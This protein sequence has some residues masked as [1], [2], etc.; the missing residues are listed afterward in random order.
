MQEIKDPDIINI[1]L[2]FLRETEALEIRE[3]LVLTT[4]TRLPAS[5]KFN[6][7]LEVIL[8]PFTIAQDK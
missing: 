4:T 8:L 7:H 2:S 1:G 6:S 3:K 5:S